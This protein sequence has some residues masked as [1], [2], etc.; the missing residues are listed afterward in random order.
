MEMV[1]DQPLIAKYTAG[2]T[3]QQVKLS[4]TNARQSRNSF[5]LILVLFVLFLD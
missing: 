3:V 1:D 2:H 4:E 5:S